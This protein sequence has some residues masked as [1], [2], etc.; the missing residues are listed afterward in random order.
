MIGGELRGQP[1]KL[2]QVDLKSR[3]VKIF[4]NISLFSIIRYVQ[5]EI[6]IDEKQAI[7]VDLGEI[8]KFTRVQ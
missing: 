6:S 8:C 2:L 4:S 5:A 1:A 7:R 3:T